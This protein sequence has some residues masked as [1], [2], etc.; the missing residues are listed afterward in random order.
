MVMQ[1]LD[2]SMLNKTTT[3]KPKNTTKKPKTG[4]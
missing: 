2:K 1:K 3:L 4:I